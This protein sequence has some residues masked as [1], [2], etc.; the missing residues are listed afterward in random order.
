MANDV[1]LKAGTKIII[2][3]SDCNPT[4]GIGLTGVEDTLFDF[5]N[6]LTAT[7]EQSVKFGFGTPWGRRWRVASGLEFIAAPTAG[8]TVDYY[9]GYSDSATV[10][11]ENPGNLSGAV[12][13]YQG[14][15]ADAAS[16]IEALLQLY[17]IGSLVCTNDIAVQVAEIGIITPLANNACLVIHNLSGQTIADVDGVETCVQII[18]IIDEIQT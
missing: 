9:I 11:N 17:Y 18:E 2:G 4:A 3:D 10:G 8:L 7:L 15:G 16:G 6:F 1:L 14:Y 13:P 5:T 12:G